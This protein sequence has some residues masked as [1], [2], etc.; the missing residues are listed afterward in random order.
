MRKIII[1]ALLCIS[2]YSNAQFDG[3]WY[4]FRIEDI[5]LNSITKDKFITGRIG[6]YN[7]SKEY[8]ARADTLNIIKRIV[9]NDS[10]LYIITTPETGN[11][12]ENQM[13]KFIYHKN[14]NTLST[15]F[16]D[17]LKQFQELQSSTENLE[18][19]DI[20]KFIR[21]DNSNSSYL[22]YYRKETI[23]TYISYAKL[24]EQP[25]DKIIQLYENLSLVYTAL[26]LKTQEE[27]LPYFLLKG[28]SKSVIQVPA[29]LEL[30]INPLVSAEN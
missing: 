5:S 23:D 16:F 20:E 13:H 25:T 30:K 11:S 6:N 8:I 7:S 26:H 17:T 9:K 12:K 18:I 14:S 3:N 27:M 15:F 19:K 2:Q 21:D 22:T 10:I 1:I 24:I 29:Y 28:M 4:T